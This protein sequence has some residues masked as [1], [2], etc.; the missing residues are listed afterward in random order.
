MLLLTYISCWHSALRISSWSIAV[1]CAGV[2]GIYRHS[3]EPICLEI[4]VAL[5]YLHSTLL[6]YDYAKKHQPHY[7]ESQAITIMTEIGNAP[8]ASMLSQPSDPNN[9]INNHHSVT[10]QTQAASLVGEPLVCQWQGCQQPNHSNA[11]T[12]YVS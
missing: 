8:T 2:H 3:P 11:E 10:P 9:I 5:C 12:L 6:Y 7:C 1:A 4:R